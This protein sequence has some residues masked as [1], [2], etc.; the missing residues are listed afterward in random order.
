MTQITCR[1]TPDY[2]PD[3]PP[4]CLTIR[5]NGQVLLDQAITEPV[6]FAHDISDDEAH[7]CLEFEMTN[8]TFAHSPW[9]SQGRSMGDCLLRIEHVQFDG[10]ELDQVFRKA[11]QYQ[12]RRNN[13]AGE[14]ITEEFYEVMGCNG[15][16]R[17]EFDSPTYLWLLE[18]M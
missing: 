7:H 17:F 10:I 15:V 13:P 14:L 1:I 12:H 9:D 8:K 2:F 5:L 6:D 11:A 3:A 4:L 16:I 18:N